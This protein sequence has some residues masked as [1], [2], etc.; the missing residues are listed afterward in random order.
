MFRKLDSN[1]LSVLNTQL[2]GKILYIAGK[3][4]NRGGGFLSRNK[5]LIFKKE[6]QRA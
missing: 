2:E 1:L 6:E 4:G 3:T 5:V